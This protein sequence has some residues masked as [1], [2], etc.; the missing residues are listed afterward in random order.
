MWKLNKDVKPIL[1]YT[2][3]DSDMDVIRT[4]MLDDLQDKEANPSE[5]LLNQC[6]DGSFSDIEYFTDKKDT[7][8][9]IK[10]LDNI[11]L[12]QSAAYTPDNPYYQNEELINA[13]NKAI[14][15]W[16]LQEFY[17]DWNGWWNGLG[18]GPKIADILLYPNETLDE[19]VIDKLLNK[20]YKIT[21]FAEGK[22]YSVKERKIDS[23]GGNLTDAVSYSLKYA[24][25][26]QD[27]AAIKYL[28]E[29]MENEL[30]PFPSKKLFHHRYDVEGIKADMSFQQ[31]YEMLYLGGYGEVFSDGMNLFIRYTSQTQFALSDDALNFYQ[32]FLLDGMQYAMRARYRDIN[33][34]GRGIVR[35]N[36]L[37]GIYQ[38]V[39]T[40]CKV[41]L[42]TGVKLNRE[43]EL[44]ALIETRNGSNDSGAGGHKYFW[45]SDYQVYNGDNYM[46]SVRSASKRTKNSEALNGENVLGHYLGAGAT[47]YYVNGD[48]YY[49]ILPLWDW[50]KI[51]GTTA[52]QGFLPYG[53]DNTY[54]RMGKTSFVGGVSTGSIG[55]SCLDYK[56]NGVKAK[57]SWFMFDE[58]VMCLA[59]D[60]SSSKKGDLY[61]CLNQTSLRGEIEYSISETACKEIST[62]QSGAFDW[63]YNNKIAYISDNNISLFAGEKTGDWKT[64][65]ERVDS[66]THTDTVLELGISHGNK[67]KNE[68]YEYMVLMNTTPEKAKEYS[69]N[70]TINVL[71]NNSNC[72]AVWNRDT[73]TLM[74][75]FWKAGSIL[76]PDNKKLSVNKG[77]AIVCE[78][79]DNDYLL[80]VSDPKQKAKSVVITI[81]SDQIQ[82]DLPTGMYSGQTACAKINCR[83]LTDTEH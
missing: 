60:I 17:C 74:A 14:N 63:I 57:K 23:T 31:H 48:E 56:D 64:I 69:E 36:E 42:N 65:S 19:Q 25:I 30:R 72:Q 55:M 10:H 2:W 1:N 81:D 16:V 32:D 47:M 8:H 21:C 71:S 58:G 45:C 50:N 5:L 76:L 77:C 28:T 35:E 29:L 39:V 20:L 67:P 4:R 49:N 68:K 43:N 11:L 54:V 66:K 73:N 9:P 15:Y 53:K 80:Y 75:T 82:I 40:G 7:W 6:S 34:S 26:K 46:A 33:V 61:T 13:I 37:I 24:V 22:K 12:M 51:P 52:V 18:S 79:S 59:T 3:E 70:P 27:G 78:K 62:Q 83:H 44:K 38:Q 41:L